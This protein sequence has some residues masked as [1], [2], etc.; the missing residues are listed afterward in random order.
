MFLLKMFSRAWLLATLL[1]FAGTAVCVRLGIWQLD[2]LEQR[3]AFNAQVNAMRAMSALDLNRE[4]P[5]D[6]ATMEWRTVKVTGEYDLDNQFAL[7]NQVNGNE[8]GYHLI[9]LLKFGDQAILVDRGFIP[10]DG[11]DSPTGWSRYDERGVVTIEGQIRLG[12]DVQIGGNPEARNGDTNQ[13]RF[14]NSINLEGIA[15]QIPYPVLRVFIQPNANEADTSYPIPY[16]PKVDVT[17]GSHFGYAL[18]WFTFAAI[19]FFGYPFYLK[20]QLAENV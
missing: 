15:A 9:T 14:W 7:R 19:L 2:R 8:Y 16:Q 17:E 4:V 12:D 5:K 13:L 3:R 18:Q 6:I 20:K 11:N 1:V 10:A